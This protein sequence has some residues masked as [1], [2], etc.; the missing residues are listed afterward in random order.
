MPNDE[1]GV[2]LRRMTPASQCPRMTPDTGRVPEPKLLV[3]SWHT[4]PMYTGDRGPA[5]GVRVTVNAGRNPAPGR[6]GPGPG[7]PGDGQCRPEPGP[8][9]A[10]AR[11]GSNWPDPGRPGPNP[12]SAPQSSARDD[13]NPGSAPQSS[14]RDDLD[15]PQ[16]GQRSTELCPGR[17]QPGQRSTEL[18]PERPRPGPPG[19][20]NFTP[21]HR[22]ASGGAH[23]STER[24][25][26]RGPADPDRA[27]SNRIGRTVGRSDGPFCPGRPRPGPPGKPNFTPIHR[28]ASGA[29]SS[30]ER[31]PGRRAV[32]G[33]AL[34]T[35]PLPFVV[36]GPRGE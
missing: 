6:P 12:G 28:P 3:M 35:L 30:T 10:G 18:C 14:A 21:I 11:S 25:P 29:H 8:G 17:P 36:P 20:P 7:R 22:P 24:C 16:P 2:Y 26:G 13:P 27:S 5:T 31:C 9:P 1:F 4:E 34:Q 32:P 33:T 15:D 19:T 23:N